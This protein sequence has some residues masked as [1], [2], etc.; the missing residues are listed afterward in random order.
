MKS[1]LSTELRINNLSLS[2]IQSSFSLLAMLGM[3]AC[4]TL[5]PTDLSVKDSLYVWSDSFDDEAEE[6][7]RETE[8]Q[9]IRSLEESLLN[10]DVQLIF[11]EMVDNEMAEIENHEKD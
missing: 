2:F 9:S 4:N 1:H 8:Y 7:K 3:V 6:N 5:P 11:E 10:N